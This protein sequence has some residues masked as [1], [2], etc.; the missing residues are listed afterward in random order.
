MKAL[1]KKA[2]KTTEFAEMVVLTRAPKKAPAVKK[3]PKIVEKTDF[4]VPPAFVGPMLPL[5]N[6]M[7]NVAG[8]FETLELSNSGNMKFNFN[9]MH[10]EQLA[11]L[12]TQLAH[13]QAVLTP[14]KATEVKL[15]TPHK[16][17]RPTKEGACMTVWEF[18]DK[19]PELTR[20]EAQAA[21]DGIVNAITVGV[22]FGHWTKAQ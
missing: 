14:A 13:S 4:I 6:F 17:N 8:E 18:L 16:Y 21:L 3:T 11:H 2:I 20:K 10:K 9:P 1:N 12:A 5:L 22:Q 19:N 7:D 15:S